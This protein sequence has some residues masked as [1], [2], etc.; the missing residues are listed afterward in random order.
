MDESKKRTDLPVL[1]LHNLDYSWEQE[2]IDVALEEVETVESA[3]KRQGHPV[4][5]IAVIDA[6]LE[7]H[8]RS[9]DPN[10]HIILNWCEELPGMPRSEARVA[11]ILEQMNFV[12]T[13]SSSHCLLNSWDKPWVKRQLDLHA[14]P[15]PS[16]QLCE[17]PEADGWDCFPAIV[18]PAYNHSSYGVSSESVVMNANE[19]INRL[20]YVID[21][22]GPA[23]IED[24]IDGREFHVTLWGNGTIEMLP[25]AEMD[26]GRFKDV[27]DR[28]CTFDSKF[29]PGSSH[30]EQI[31]LLV[32][33][34]LTDAEQNNLE[35]V[36]K[37]AYALLDCRDYARLD[38]RMRD[39]VFYVLDINPN[40][41]ISYE[42]T[43]ASSAELTGYSYG[44]MLS[45]LVNLAA[46]RH[47]VFGAQLV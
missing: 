26:F 29:K 30:Y 37:S 10:E 44:A 8:L 46:L 36:V 43:M 11:Q 3:I 24:F 27:H 22:F 40:P 17:K 6:N 16:W 42:T 12:F 33:A 1:V 5:N 9:Y 28:L 4:D 41:D 45:R 38:L 31:N 2:D 13:G 18:K 32:P 39:G 15:T 47:P 23:V 34:P 19:L 7:S 35:R 21:N 14:V 25:P 20:R